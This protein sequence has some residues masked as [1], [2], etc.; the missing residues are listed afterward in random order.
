MRYAT[1]LF[2]LALVGCKG[3]E[4]AAPCDSLTLT[5]LTAECRTKVRAACAR[6]A[7]VVDESCPTLKAC[8]AR[9]KAWHD[10]R[11][12]GAGVLGEGG[13]P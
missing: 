2:V 11:D 1:L 8:D 12:G 9:I 10:C 6:D 7:G 13:A 5:E 4:L 3:T